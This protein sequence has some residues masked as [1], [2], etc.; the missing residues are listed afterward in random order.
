ENVHKGTALSEWYNEILAEALVASIRKRL[1][2]NPSVGLRIIEIGAGTGGTTASILRKLKPYRN[3][4]EEYCYTDLSKA[5]LFHAEEHYRPGHPFLCTKIFDVE[6]ALGPQEIAAGQYDYVI[7][8]NVLHATRDIRRTLHNVKAALRTNGLLLLNEISGKFLLSQVTFGLLKG[9]WLSED[10]SIRIPGSPGL[11]P[12]SWNRVLKEVGFETVFFPAEASHVLGQQII[13]AESNGI[14]RQE[15]LGEIGTSLVQNDEGESLSAHGRPGGEISNGPSDC[16]LREETLAFFGQLFSRVLRMDVDKIDVLEPLGTYGLDSILIS[17]VNEIL[18]QD[19]SGIGS[20]LLFKFQTITAL[21]EYFMATHRE[22]LIKAL[23]RN[24]GLTDVMSVRVVPDSGAPPVRSKDPRRLGAKACLPGQSRREQGA[25]AKNNSIAIIGMSGRYPDAKDLNEYWNLLKEGKDCIGD[26]PAGRW[27]MKDFFHPDPK[28]A[29]SLGKSYSKQGGFLDNVDQFDPQFFGISPQEA[30]FMDP[31]ERLFL[32]VVWECLESAGFISPLWQRTPRD[33]GVFVGVSYNNYQLFLAD[34][35]KKMAHYSVG[36]Q[37]YSI[38]N[39]IS[40]LFNFIGPSFAL[41]TACSSSLFAIH[42][43]CESIRHGSTSLA[44]AGGVNLS[45]HPSKYV[46]LC[47]SGFASSK[48]HCHAF[49]ADGD[50][51]VPSEGVGVVLLKSLVQARADGDKILAVIKGSGVSQDGRTQGYTVPNPVAQSRAIEAALDQAGVHPETISYVEAHGTGTAL[52]DPI[53]IQGLVDAY[54]KYTNRKQYCAIGSVKSNIGHGEAAAGVGQLAKTVLQMQHKTLVAS[55]MHGPPNPN[56]DFKET[57]FYVQENLSPWEV[58]QEEGNGP[59]PRRA[60]ISSFGAGGVNVHLIVEEA[61]A[62]HL[63]CSIAELKDSFS[64]VVPLSAH[65]A[66]QLRPMAKNLLKYLE[67]AKTENELIENIAYT[68]QTKR[69]LLRHRLAFVVSDTSDLVTQLR[70]YLLDGSNGSEEIGCYGAD[71]KR[72]AEEG[73]LNGEASG[74]GDIGR[75]VGQADMSLLARHWVRGTAIDWETMYDRL[76]PPDYLSLPTYPFLKKRYW[77]TD[78]I[79]SNLLDE[80]ETGGGR[81]RSEPDGDTCSIPDQRVGGDGAIVKML[82]GELLT[83]STPAFVSE[84][85]DLSEM[86]RKERIEDWLAEEVRLALGFES[87][88]AIDSHTGFFD[89]GMESIQSTKLVDDCCKRFG[90]DLPDTLLFDYSTANQVSDYLLESIPWE[91]HIERQSVAPTGLN[92]D[93]SERDPEKERNDG[94]SASHPKENNA[95]EALAIVSM[96][97]HFPGACTTPEAFWELLK[98]GR[99]GLCDVPLDRW[100]NERLYDEKIKSGKLYIKQSNFIAEDVSLFDPKLFNISPREAEEMDPQQRLL[101]ELTWEGLER[102]G[103]APCELRGKQVGVFIGIIGADYAMLPRDPKKI[104]PYTMTG[105]TSHMASGRISHVFGFH[106]PAL[107]FDTACSSSLV[108]LH[109]ACES[110]QNRECELAVA[111]GVG[112]MLTPESFIG[113]CQMKALSRDG[114]CK[115]FA[116]GGDGYGR[117]EGAGLVVLKRLSDAKRDG[118]KILATIEGS[119]MNHDGASSGLTVPNGI[120]QKALLEQAMLR[121]RVH[122]DEIGYIEAHGTGTSLGDPIEFNALKQVFGPTRSASNP[123]AIGTCKA[124]IGHLE[125][126]AGIA[127]VIKAV[128]CLQHKELS[129]HIN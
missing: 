114:R 113:L 35:M 74:L 54:G 22:T 17:G 126:A 84:L 14:V 88:E 91:A 108:A 6:K 51:L 128:L 65:V 109:Q 55:L 111:G 95:R 25:D 30:R 127:G 9:W 59:Q 100:D 119:A 62:D 112:L 41:D 39:R 102:G 83:S 43:A 106:G 73:G 107:S 70:A 28:E 8:T 24:E 52:G 115:P 11:Y 3:N 60:G 124:N 37:T 21:S 48:G 99:E 80:V 93:I 12:D 92:V 69:A 98:T 26:I 103:F 58:H 123:L 40:Y 117:G 47:A 44:L 101:L 81:T 68:L 16:A 34:A 104:S 78:L 10:E 5:F 129:P 4:I 2:D 23:R 97:C 86:D 72:A 67:E 19:F 57:P 87:E 96:A 118:D 76:S 66:S 82:D 85:L 56:I 18:R 29:V 89:L 77:I 125:A 32:E 61:P 36:S 45:L 64:C 46:T 7:A 94:P 31:Q 116:A 75:F 120:A 27:P 122:P 13:L 53:E 50:G 63:E 38:A 79:D 15:A 71:S 105:I 49:A 20:A 110:L 121:A 90:L 33:I 1:D 42:Q